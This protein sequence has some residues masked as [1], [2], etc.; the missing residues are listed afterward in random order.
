MTPIPLKKITVAEVMTQEFMKGTKP[1]SH[2]LLMYIIG[3]VTGAVQKKSK[4]KEDQKLLLGRFEATRISD[5]QVFTA[6]RLYLPDN[7]YQ[8]QLA[9][10]SAPTADG[11]VNEVEFGFMIGWR[12]Q[13]SSPTGYVFSVEP[14][15]DTRAQDRLA[16][17]RKLVNETDLLKRFNLPA[18]AAPTADKKK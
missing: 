15:T 6:E 17:V 2:T 4:H 3:A 7:D 14:M 9:K 16:S 12:P 10:A 13:S 1:T 18:L 8:E 5:R 11:E